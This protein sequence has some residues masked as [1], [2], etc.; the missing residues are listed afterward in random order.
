MPI[1]AE[2]LVE[3]SERR[4]QNNRLDP[5]SVCTCD[6]AIARAIA[7]RIVVTHDVE[8]AERRGNS[9]A[10]RCAADSAATIGMR[11]V[12]IRSDRMVSMPSPA[13]ITSCDTPNRTAWPRRSPIA[14]LGVS[15]GALPLPS[16]ASQVRCAPVMRPPRSVTDAIIA[17]QLSVGLCS[18]GL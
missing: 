1:S 17:G 5:D 13:A 3:V 2:I 8:S 9:M 6:Q 16:S 10:A 12:A 7:G 18:P 14:R 11:G 4:R 15:T